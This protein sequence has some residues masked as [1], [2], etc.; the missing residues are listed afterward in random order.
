MNRN[1]F[2]I[3]NSERSF[4]LKQDFPSSWMEE[5][6]DF[7]PGS[8][9]VVVV[10]S[11]FLEIMDQIVA[12]LDNIPVPFDLL[13]TSTSDP[14]GWISSE[15]LP[16]LR[17]QLHLSVE[18]RG[19]DIWPLAQLVNAGLLDSYD[20]VLKVHTKKSPWLETV[21]IPSLAKSGSD[22]LN[23]SLSFLLGSRDEVRGIL[24][25]FMLDP[26]LGFYA[27]SS[28]ILG[29]KYWTSNLVN[30]TDLAKR[31]QL[32]VVAEEVQFV[33][34]SMYWCKAFI[35]Q[36]LR[37][38]DLTRDDFEDEDGQNDGT[39]AHAIERLLGILC[40]ESGMK[41]SH[42]T[43][44]HNEE[45]TSKVKALCNDH[46][47]MEVSRPN[48]LTILVYYLPQFHEFEENSLWWGE[49]FTEWSNVTS[50][51]PL[52]KGHN[53]PLLPQGTG[54]YDLSDAKT[55][56]I[57]VDLAN[58][59]GIDA[60]MF[61]YYWFD[62]KVLMDT[63]IRNFLNSDLEMKFSIL[64][65]NENWT[66]KWD[67]GD[68]EILIEQTDLDAF[69][70]IEDVMKYLKD[71]RYLQIEDKPVLSVYRVGKIKNFESVVSHWNL[72]CQEEGL[73]G[74]YILSV[75]VP[76]E[77]G[78]LDALEE[79]DLQGNS[80]I[81]GT[82]AFPPHNMKFDRHHT[83]EEYV[84]SGYI[85]D[86]RS[87]VNDQIRCLRLG[88][89]K[90]CIPGVMV[91]YDNTAR[92]GKKSHIFF[93]S[94]PYLFRRWLRSAI[95]AVADKPSDQRYVVINAWNEWAESAVLEETR[96]FGK[97]YLLAIKSLL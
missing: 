43:I 17:S 76:F 69:S 40:V 27:P 34:G 89:D 5:V 44:G 96:A 21:N 7:L 38:L 11:H 30:A 47:S 95:L 23:T 51:K 74:L 45:I 72:R 93:G 54:F 36:G 50:S 81:S 67:G 18:N 32:P 78:G 75:D 79:I 73:N 24:E 31:I 26:D 58:S 28:S 13:T 12:S 65:A 2:D 15:V 9:I 77:F 14:I 88:I 19:R 90:S 29:S 49:G 10:H 71:P 83:I 55:L 66:R 35:L 80:S 42:S 37:S 3:W 52:F 6:R 61:Y 1:R 82:I 87:L 48:L 91:N 92:I 70:F 4:K 84:G 16:N 94:N 25:A 68:S 64:W 46:Y 59:S 97:T 60:F 22:W 33:A 20:L 57:Q 39:T 8:K 86:Y 63:P 53:Q 41:L 56:A 85:Y 62:G